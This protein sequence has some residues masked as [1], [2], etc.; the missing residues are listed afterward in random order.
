MQ[1]YLGERPGASCR[2]EF[3][4]L[5][6]TWLQSA[7]KTNPKECYKHSYMWKWD[8]IYAG[9]ALQEF[10]QVPWQNRNGFVEQNIAEGLM[11]KL[12]GS[13]VVS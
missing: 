2:E 4:M 12:K 7:E 5:A 8:C 1:T 9:F 3:Q 11:T 6:K 13:S 10:W